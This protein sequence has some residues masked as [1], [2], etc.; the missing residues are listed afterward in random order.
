MLTRRS[1]LV[2]VQGL[3]TFGWGFAS[4]VSWAAEE[5]ISDHDLL[6]SHAG[7]RM[8]QRDF[9]TFDIPDYA[10]DGHFVPVT[11][12][13]DSPMRADNY[14]RRV[15]L[16]APHNPNTE[17]LTAR[18][19]A[20]SGQAMVKTRIRLAKSQTVYVVAESSA[21]DVSYVERAVTVL[22]SGCGGAVETG[23]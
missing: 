21:G 13:V 18:Y 6:K 11:I 15:T 22:V 20:M 1:L 4:Q 16:I 23:Q 19:S 2:M 9:F 10:E 8:P 3:F 14:V 17:V 12:H 7:G 5:P